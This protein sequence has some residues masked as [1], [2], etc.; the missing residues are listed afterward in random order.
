MD[1][2][3]DCS[4][5]FSICWMTSAFIMLEL[6]EGLLRHIQIANVYHHL[7]QLIECLTGYRRVACL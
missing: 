1:L 3:K 4:Q 6:S 2:L 7:A 5:N